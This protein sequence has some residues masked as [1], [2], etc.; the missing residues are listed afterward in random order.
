MPDKKEYCIALSR[1][2]LQTL[3]ATTNACRDLTAQHAPELRERLECILDHGS[4][5]QRPH[6]AVL[7]D[8]Y[9]EACGLDS[10]Y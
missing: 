5:A 2:E 9:C 4:S 7:E 3:V 6:A 8:D 10:D 1:V